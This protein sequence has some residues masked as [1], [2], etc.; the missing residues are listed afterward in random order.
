M[1]SAF[2]GWLRV[3]LN[4]VKRLFCSFRNLFRQQRKLFAAALR[5][6]THKVKQQA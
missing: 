6:M 3:M 1:S 2:L 5:T 4:E